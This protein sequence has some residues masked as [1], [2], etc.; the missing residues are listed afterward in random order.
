MTKMSPVAEPQLRPGQVTMMRALVVIPKPPGA[1]PDHYAR[2][3]RAPDDAPCDAIDLVAREVLDQFNRR[4][5]AAQPSAAE[6]R[7]MCLAAARMLL[8][9][10]ALRGRRR[11]GRSAPSP[12]YGMTRRT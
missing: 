7:L 3:L 5:I 12:K 1:P 9:V 11:G 8:A 2:I 4:E 6:L 10:R